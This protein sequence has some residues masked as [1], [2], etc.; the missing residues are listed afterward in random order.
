MGS[1]RQ[2]A[3]IIIP[4]NQIHS[5]KKKVETGDQEDDRQQTASI[6]LPAKT[7][8][9]SSSLTDNKTQKDWQWYNNYNNQF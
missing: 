5:E 2:E 4:N 9:I 1:K 8:K 6:G 7:K 3:L